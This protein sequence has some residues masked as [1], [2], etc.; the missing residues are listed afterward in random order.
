M[1]NK[2]WIQASVAAFVVL[3]VL[4]FIIHGMM[5]QGIYQQ[6]ALVWRPM[7]ELQKTMWMMWLGYLIF[8]PFFALI[9]I[10]GYEKNKPALDQGIRFG[11]LVGLALAPMQSLA[12]YS[13]LP[14]PGNLAFYWFLGG[15][16]E[17]IAL[18]V[19]VAMVYGR[20]KARRA[21]PRKRR[22]QR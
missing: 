9:F 19:T 13:V 2:R 12:W 21:K 20:V 18:G 11:V 3:F 10:K 22:R 7:E 16:V 1:D 6:T 14:I 4:E 17:F 15:M 8:A 5:L